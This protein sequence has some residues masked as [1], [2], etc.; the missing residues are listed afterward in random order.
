MD[1]IMSPTKPA[2]ARL[3]LL[4]KRLPKSAKAAL[5]V[6]LNPH[7]HIVELW[8]KSDQGLG[9][10]IAFV[11]ERE[12]E[13][14]GNI[15]NGEAG[16]GCHEECEERDVLRPYFVLGGRYGKGGIVLSRFYAEEEKA[17]KEILGGLMTALAVLTAIPPAAIARRAA[18]KRRDFLAPMLKK[19]RKAIGAT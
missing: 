19:L 15:C 9:W 13:G 7:G 2:I 16:W 18:A 3:L 6:E 12:W 8:N 4:L 14:S 5:H 17:N 1:L 10:S 11:C